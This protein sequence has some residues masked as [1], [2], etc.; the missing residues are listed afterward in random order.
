MTK[1]SSQ[2]TIAYVGL[3]SNL[4]NRSG[5][6]DK[7]VDCLNS[8]E[9]VR[10]DALSSIIETLPLGDQTQDSYLNAVARI[11]TTLAADRLH[12]QMM[13]VEDSLG[14]TRAQKWAARTIDLDLLLYGNEIVDAAKL[15]VP[16]SRMHLRS[17]VLKGMCELAPDLRHPA[18][19]RSMKTLATRLNGE[20]FAINEQRPQLISV[21]GIIGVGKTTLTKA[22]ANCLNC[23]V[24][25]EAYDENP[26]LADVYAG[27]TEFAL[28]SQL[29]FLDSRVRQLKSS[30]LEPGR[31]VI[32]DYVF[33]KE[34][35]Y[36]ARTLD[37]DQFV[38]YKE[39]NI[40]ATPLVAK[41][42]LVVYLKELPAKCLE[43]IRQ[44]NRPYEQRIELETLEG[45][46]DDYERLFD[47]WRTSPVIRFGPD[48]F[49]CLSDGSVEEL[50]DEIRCYIATS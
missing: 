48:E 44:R 4:G 3:G 30:A 28:D 39:R 10:V 45:F 19:K 2:L 13:L 35:I 36:A 16:H 8:T 29:N 6:I 37:T 18:L 22:L 5:F 49:D 41:P 7:A 26:Y 34:M 42:V 24:L 46:A 43:R 38:R 47:G 32:A 11:E 20:D 15:R 25:A 50:A 33:D 27:R 17:F 1:V 40:A 12:E 23:P 14:R 9:G 21:A 31:A